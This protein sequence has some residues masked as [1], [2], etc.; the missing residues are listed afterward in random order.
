MFQTSKNKNSWKVC[1][2]VCLLGTNDKKKKNTKRKDK[3]KRVQKKPLLILIAR[4]SF[5]SWYACSEICSAEN[6]DDKMDDGPKGVYGYI[7]VV[8][9]GAGGITCDEI[10]FWDF[11]D[12]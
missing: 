12:W 5:V 9:I 3:K 2:C 1:V 6:L 4:F 11:V 8:S 7:D 10:V